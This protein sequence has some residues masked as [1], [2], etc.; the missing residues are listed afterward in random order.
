MLDTTGEL[1]WLL[2]DLVGRIARVRQAMI[3]TGDG[4]PMGTSRGME[5]SEAERFAALAAGC[6]GLARTVSERVEGGDIRQTVIELEKAFLFVV[7]AGDGT[8][9]AVVSEGDANIGLIAYE[10]ARLVKRV[11]R[12]LATSTRSAGRPDGTPGGA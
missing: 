9:L 10:M 1:N 3:L 12:H 7:A 8:C 5:T 11:R 6:H 4:L 2:D